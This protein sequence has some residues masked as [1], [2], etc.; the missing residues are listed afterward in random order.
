[1]RNGS[2]AAV[3]V[4]G[5][6]HQE[7][8][9]FR[10]SFQN[11]HP[12]VVSYQGVYD[13]GV[14]MCIRTVWYQ[15]GLPHGL[16]H[17]LSYGLYACSCA[18]DSYRRRTIRRFGRVRDEADGSFVSWRIHDLIRKHVRLVMSH[19]DVSHAVS[20]RDEVHDASVMG[21]HMHWLLDHPCGTNNGCALR[22]SPQ[23]GMAI[24]KG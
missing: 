5:L 22:L 6:F 20:K 2:N 15:Y 10:C 3:G 4:L 9:G 21:F 19:P 12:C 14:R 16:S 23:T 7:R 17:G 18:R 1:M 13:M 24:E 8:Q 11:L